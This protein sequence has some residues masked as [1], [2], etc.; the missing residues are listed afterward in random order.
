MIVYS[1]SKQKF[2]SDVFDNI[3]ADEIIEAFERV[4]GRSTATAEVRSWQNSLQY[5]YNILEDPDIPNDSGIAIEYQ[6]PQT[7]KR[8][9]FIIAGLDDEN[10]ESAVLIELKQWESAELTTMDGIVGTFVGGGNREVNHPSYQ[11]WSYAAMI[12]DFNETVQE[13]NIKLQPCAYL[14]NY[15]QDDVITNEFYQA[16]L[17]KAP[18][19]LKSD[20]AKLQT[21]IKRFV[22]YGDNKD[23]L[24]RID[25]S[26]I[27]PSK[28]LADNLS[29]LLSG[30]QEF[31]MIDD[32]KLVYET[33][34]QLS[35]QADEDN[36]QVLIVE[37]GPGTGKSVVAINLLVAITKMQKMVQYA[38][39]NAAPR[40]V[41]EA[42]LVGTFKKSQ[43]SNLFSGTG[44]YHDVMANIFDVLIVDEAH[45]LNA[46]SGI[47]QN[48]GENQIK[49][50]VDASKLSIF[51]IDE[52]QRVT[53]QDIGDK[54]EINKWAD[55]VGAT[56]H[57][58]KLESQ[59]RCNGSD[60]YLS[61]LDN[62]LQIRETANLSIGDLGYDFSVID[63]PNKLREVIYEKNKLD[64]KARM[65]AGY[66]WKWVSKKNPLLD[67]IIFPELNFS[68][69]WN[70]D[71]DGMLW[72]MKP[73]SVKEIGCIHTCQ[74]LEVDYVGVIIG[75]DLVVR[76]GKIITDATKRASADR[77]V[78]GYKKLLKED[79]NMAKMVGDMIVKNTYRTLMTRGQKGCYIFS[80]DTET[81]EYFS[82]KIGLL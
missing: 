47:Y 12:E 82:N 18:V 33:A 76:N 60:G 11:A 17:E 25:H 35:K 19:F 42:K 81:Q 3:I 26:K 70:L 61:W 14:H 71:T 73:D 52:D 80:T 8:V 68:A 32:Q 63:S 4:L 31:I 65:V 1:S 23:L 44:S 16:Y 55:S 43:I 9:D 48:I 51:F 27:R 29:S 7:S 54:E 72:I 67:D 5:M 39:R 30:N 58:L 34:L 66:C 13:E 45:R 50:I 38:T 64:N 2:L 57:N 75:P 46:K 77:S 20:A 59:F 28:K 69:K 40:H 36:K 79:P 78:F 56:V 62:T 24:Y 49:E 15:Q 37:G 74:G 21:F 6:I 53:L 41:Y 22:K 10:R